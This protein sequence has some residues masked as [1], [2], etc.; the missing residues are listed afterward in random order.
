MRC[1]N[2]ATDFAMKFGPR[3]DKTSAGIECLVKWLFRQ[4]MT[5][6]AVVLDMGYAS[7]QCEKG[8]KIVKM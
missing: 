7:G 1:R 4:V 8:S 6:S 3:S 5:V 2:S